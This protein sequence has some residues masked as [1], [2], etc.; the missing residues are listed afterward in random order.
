MVSVVP[1]CCRR[2]VARYRPLEEIRCNDLD[3]K[4][5]FFL[6]TDTNTL[7]WE[8][9]SRR[10]HCDKAFTIF[11]LQKY[12]Q[13]PFHHTVKVLLLK[14]YQW[15]QKGETTYKVINRTF[16]SKSRS[17]AIG[18]FVFT[19]AK[20]PFFLVDIYL[21]DKKK[22]LRSLVQMEKE[23]ARLNN[24]LLCPLNSSR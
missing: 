4:L 13:F 17:L 19:F 20:M 23:I 8:L 16:C 9:L 6:Y 21:F 3:V 14:S 7:F 10:R 24:Q 18:I 11:K 1:T 15:I 12:T 2:Q 22:T 5:L